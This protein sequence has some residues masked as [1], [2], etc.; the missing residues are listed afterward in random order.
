MRL[1]STI[2]I[3]RTP[4]EVGLFL[5]DIANVTKWDRGVGSSRRIAGSLGVG[6]NSR[7]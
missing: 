6:S 4:E 3:H 5:S 1:E 7:V 2:I